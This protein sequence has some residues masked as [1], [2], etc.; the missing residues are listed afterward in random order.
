MA[1]MAAVARSTIIVESQ[2]ALFFAVMAG[3]C[4]ELSLASLLSRSAKADHDAREDE[5]PKLEPDSRGT[6][7]SMT[8][9][10]KG[11]AV[12]HCGCIKEGA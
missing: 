5:S 6:S 3:L 4:A 1:G 12:T 9:K 11:R 8:I 7:P 2:G 10:R